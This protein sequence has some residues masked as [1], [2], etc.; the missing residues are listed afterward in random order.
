[1]SAPGDHDDAHDP[2]H[3]R[4]LAPPPAIRRN[5]R[6][7]RPAAFA[8]IALAAA[9]L[10]WSLWPEY[11]VWVEN[12]SRQHTIARLPLTGGPLEIRYVHSIYREPAT[13]EFV[14]RP[15]GL[16]LV[17][18]ASGSAAVL[19]YYARPE[20]ITPAGD[21]YELRPAPQLYRELALLAGETGKRTVVYAGHE[22]ALHRLAAD[23]DRVSLSVTRAPR[24]L[25]FW[26][27][28]AGAA[29]GGRPG[30]GLTGRT[31]DVDDVRH[32]FVGVVRAA[33]ERARFDVAEAQVQPDQLE[34]GELNWRHKTHDRQ[35]LQAG[36]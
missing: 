3:A 21:G 31:G 13:E 33:D 28:P 27:R 4:A 30:S 22:L 17:R 11:T 24:A 1:V 15:E 8:A 34:L 12:T 23:G 16:E 6:W 29:G 36:S 18:I 32:L 14:A 2:L 9:L 7:P 25:R 35:V 26:N 5:S 20:P 10:L 19:E